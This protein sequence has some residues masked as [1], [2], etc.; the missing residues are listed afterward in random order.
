MIDG[1]YGEGG[2]QIIRTALSL[3]A[4]TGQAVEIVNIRSRRSKPGLQPQ[5]LTAVQAA[6]AICN[7]EVA[8]AAV[9]STRL[10]FA[11]QSSP[12]PGNYRWDIGTA[13]ATTL[14]AQTVLLPLAL[15][16]GPSRVT[17][18]GGTHVPH[19]PAVE[20]L[21]GVYLPMLRHAGCAVRMDSP[22]AGFY[23][24]GGGEITLDIAGG[25]RPQAIHLVERGNLR[26]LH[27][28][29]VTAGLPAH[30]AER[31]AATLELMTRSFS[32]GPRFTITKREQPSHGRGAAVVITAEYDGGFGG[33]SA[34]G[35]R[36]VPMDT[37]AG[38]ACIDFLNW[39]DARTGYAA[40]DEHLADQL[41]LPAALAR[42]ESRWSA[43]VVSEHLR[44]A[45]WV[46]QQ[47]L[48]ITVTIDAPDGAPGIITLCR[49]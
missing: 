2:G 36:G 20:Y 5:H 24:R 48:P 47:F 44:T 12:Q 33:F 31:G 4:I 39:W 45:L 35:A 22:R 42:G 32:F 9:G 38:Q 11:P 49:D 25:Y 23:P 16:A 28:T 37:V 13:G 46:A 7:A 10:R 43:P 6:A 29:I 41:V 26:A 3:A 15:A 18:T 27:A 34:L 40:C 30:V 17:I 14:V 8:G 1:L 19:A 21:E